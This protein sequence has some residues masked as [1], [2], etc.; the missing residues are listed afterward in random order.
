MVATGSVNESDVTLKINL[1]IRQSVCID[2]RCYAGESGKSD[3]GGRVAAMKLTAK[4]PAP[5]PRSAPG[6]R[7]EK[8]LR[9]VNFMRRGVR[10]N[11]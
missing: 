4:R 10:E 6:R 11:M 7:S 9:C 5:M 8:P 2:A 1:T 3:G